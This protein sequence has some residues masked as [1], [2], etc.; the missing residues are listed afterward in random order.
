MKRTLL[1]FTLSLL[2]S[3]LT[4]CTNSNNIKNNTSNANNSGNTNTSSQ[5]LKVKD[6]YPIKENV[7]YTY[8]GN[9]NEY[10]SYNV[11]IDYTSGDKVQQRVN[12]GGTEAVKVVEVKDGKV[13]RMLSRGEVYYRENLL[14]VKDSDNEV[15]LMEP[16]MKGTTWK[17]KDS[18]TRTIT[19]ISAD[20]TTPEGN[21]KAVEVVTEGTNGKT[22]DYYAKDVG[23]VKSVFVAGNTEI[24]SALSKIDENVS[25]VQKVSFYYPNINDNKIYY[26]D[27]DVSFKT[28]DITKQVLA[29]A[30]KDLKNSSLWQVF[31]KNTKINSLYLNKD[32]MVYIDLNKAFLTDMNAGSGYEGMII[33]SIANTFGKYYN[34][35]KVILTIDD[36]PYASG[37]ILMKKGQYIEV[38]DNQ[39]QSN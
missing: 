8:V 10:A 22:Y 19:D 23:L 18:S 5:P 11:Y 4:G 32:N 28:N 6:Y 17:L 38:K 27:K 1:I 13:T 7:K 12:N 15:L 29:A 3:I 9:G 24:S 31:S 2:L 33:Q 25:L 34:S 16:I 39:N 30:Y 35:R 36:K 21:F 20:V 26:I 14:A 37:H